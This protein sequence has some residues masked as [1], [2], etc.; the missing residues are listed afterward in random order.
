MDALI[1]LIAALGPWGILV[2]GFLF[3]AVWMTRIEHRVHLLDRDEHGRVP[4]IEVRVDD[5]AE[6][7]VRIDKTLTGIATDTGWIKHTLDRAFNR[8]NT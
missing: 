8:E 1:P 2:A 4:R 6:G 3:L 5:L 7:Q